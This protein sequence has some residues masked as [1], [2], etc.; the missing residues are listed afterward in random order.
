MI[1]DPSSNDVMMPGVRKAAIAMVALGDEV[2][3]K[4]FRFLADEEV[5]RLG[6]EISRLDSVTSKQAEKV[7]AEFHEMEMAH[8]QLSA[9][10]LEY[11]KR[12]L[13]NAFGQDRAKGIVER[14][15]RSL[16]GE[17]PTF[18]TLQKT[19]PQQVAKFIQG[20]HPQT[21]ALVLSHLDSGAAAAMLMALPAAVR[22]D[23]SMRM[24][25][26]EQISPDV[27]R[28]IAEILEQRLNALGQVT[29]Q[30]FGGVPAVAEMF[31]RLE[32]NSGQELLEQIEQTDGD[33]CQSIRNLMFV[34]EDM[35]LIDT[36]GMRE[37][38]S[39]V[40]KK[41]LTVA[42]KGTSEKLQDHF[43]NNMSERGANMLREDMEALGPVKIRE[44]EGAQQEIISA[45][46][47]LEA[48][49]VLSLK[50]AVGEQYVV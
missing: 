12:V 29:R 30:S 34:F 35:R 7:L 43:F 19:D 31:N 27:V 6:R 9:G 41:V 23:V 44:V 3:A 15:V 20:E 17:I 24:A 33:L 16:G 13:N 32:A 8:K 42:L 22:S 5:Q 25:K 46:R 36:F 47:Q 21:I 11:A 38:L 2:A 4:V 39:R 50:G 28:R 37:V 45:V 10:G 40:D 18:Q 48:E 14:L 1:N 49:G 26:L